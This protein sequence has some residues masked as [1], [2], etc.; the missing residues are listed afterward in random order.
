MAVRTKT[1]TILILALAFMGSI[2]A[3]S[4]AGSITAPVNTIGDELTVAQMDLAAVF[5]ENRG[6]VKS[7]ARY[8]TRAGALNLSFTET[9][10]GFGV[11][12]G[13]T[14]DESPAC[15]CPYS[16]LP[17]G[18]VHTY[19]LSLTFA[20][21]RP[22]TQLAGELETGGITSYFKGQ[23]D[24]WV[25]GVPNYS[26]LRYAA[27]YDG[28]DAVFYTTAARLQYDFIVAPNADPSQIRL[29]FDPVDSIHIDESGD[30]I[31]S[32]GDDSLAMNAPFTYQLI[33]GNQ[34]V[35]AS[36]FVIDGDDVVFEVGDYDRTRELVIDPVIEYVGFLGG[37]N[38]DRANDVTVDQYGHVYIVGSTSSNDGSFPYVGGPLGTPAG[39]TTFVAK[40]TLSGTG[41]EYI[42]FI[43]G[44]SEGSGIVV[45]SSGSAYVAGTVNSG[46]AFPGV[47]GP[48]LTANGMEDAFVAKINPEGTALVF[49]GFIGGQIWDY[50]YDV[51][52]DSDLNVYVTGY[53][54]SVYRGFPNVV[55]PYFAPVNPGSSGHL[56]FITKVVASGESLAYSG[57]LGGIDDSW[58]RGV[59]VDLDGSAYVV[60]NAYGDWDPPGVPVFSP[61]PTVGNNSGDVAF[62][63][64]V[65]PEGTGLEYL[66]F[67]DGIAW[68]VVVDAD[69]HV[70]FVGSVYDRYPP[71]TFPASVGPKLI[72][73]NQ[74]DGF[75]AKLHPSGT[76]FI[77]GGY[78]GGPRGE[79][80]Y[81]VAVDSSGIAYVTGVTLSGGSQYPVKGGPYSSGN[82]A[83]DIWV[84]KVK[85][86]GT[87]LLSAG[88]YGEENRDEGE[89][90]A[91]DG[92]GN[93]YIVGH[94]VSRYLETFGPWPYLTFNGGTY[95]AVI[96]KIVPNLPPLELMNGGFE[97]EGI[98]PNSADGWIGKGLLAKDRRRC[99][100]PSK[101]I[102]TVEGDC[103]FEFS[104]GL[105]TTVSR[106]IQQKIPMSGWSETG[107]KVHLVI[108]ASAK[109]LSDGAK[110]VLKSK[111]ATGQSKKTV[112]AIPT[113]TYDYAPIHVE[114]PLKHSMDKVVLVLGAYT[115]SGRLRVDDLTLEIV[116]PTSERELLPVP[117][118]VSGVDTFRR[119]AP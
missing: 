45:D 104:S 84:V 99:T 44:S 18:T 94:T 24:E 37:L 109:N 62:V 85:A 74:Y 82:G 11:L 63:A 33:D 15:D 16:T 95:D 67:L 114:A 97:T 25:T 76:S 17:R 105:P 5:E 115:A 46:Y 90:I 26:R 119:T 101:V 41:F 52:I 83:G 1:A 38:V 92:Q 88:Y 13:I 70:Y 78:I 22:D 30:L 71:H 112:V 110:I 108:H 53:T 86:D 28:I 19:G 113:G 61:D 4:A 12:T 87:G 36:R 20:G 102:G 77:Y 57:Y 81:G 100:S 31:L 103:I 91:V 49:A 27:L 107:E 10:V 40:L 47:V 42:A 117:P 79:Y 116:A 75:I 96:L 89:G 72:L 66:A 118:P 65:N 58:G 29:R 9:G 56:A 43:G 68:D 39:G 8:I 6:Q 35:V 7:D 14:D 48:D 21:A 106:K 69:E 3:A 51:A 98:D 32:F 60:G 34:Q 50:G 55:G 80:A 23:P 54:V 111:Y 59:A 73:D 64:K 93:I 2:S